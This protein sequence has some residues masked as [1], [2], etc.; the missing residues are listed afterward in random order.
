MQAC[1]I[2]EG[3]FKPLYCLHP[4]SETSNVTH[5]ERC[6]VVRSDRVNWKKNC[7]TC[8][9]YVHV[10]IHYP[11]CFYM[12]VIHL[13]SCT[14]SFQIFSIY[15]QFPIFRSLTH[16]SYCFTVWSAINTTVD[17]I[18]YCRW[19]TTC[20]IGVLWHWEIFQLRWCN[21]WYSKN[22]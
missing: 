2:V 13:I 12:P 1:S 7:Y 8:A 19:I 10:C 15:H 17:N 22:N 16:T 21:W 5:L 3:K 4:L 14:F 9:L 11:S 6:G 20:K 18:S